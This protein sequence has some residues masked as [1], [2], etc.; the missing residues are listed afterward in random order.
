MCVYAC[1][2]ETGRFINHAWE[3]PCPILLQQAASHSKKGWEEF[4]DAAITA[5][6]TQRQ[7]LVFLLWGNFAKSK[8]PLI[9]ERKH[10]VLTSAHPS[11]LS[12]SRVCWVCMGAH[13]S[14]CMLTKQICGAPYLALLLSHTGFFWL[15]ALQPNQP[16]AA[17]G[18]HA[19]Y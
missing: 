13:V 5:L 9:D 8:R 4:T 2:I 14:G 1:G 7:G 19:A 15:Q 18:W 3:R 12:A 11:G 6:S 17:A 10:H 16:A